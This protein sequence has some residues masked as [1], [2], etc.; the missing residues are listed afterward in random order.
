MDGI[1]TLLIPSKVIFYKPEAMT[2]ENVCPI[3]PYSSLKK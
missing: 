1:F 3:N 2:K